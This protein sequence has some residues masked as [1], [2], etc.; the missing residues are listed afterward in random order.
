MAKTHFWYLLGIQ[1]VNWEANALVRKV[2]G[3]VVGW[4]LRDIDDGLQ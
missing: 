2:A 3:E 4:L 1:R